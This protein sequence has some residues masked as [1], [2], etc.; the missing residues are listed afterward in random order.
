MFFLAGSCFSPL[1]ESLSY[2]A[3]RISPLC[4]RPLFTVL[5]V[6]FCFLS[7]HNPC[8]F[9]NLKRLWPGICHP[10]LNTADSCQARPTHFQVIPPHRGRPQQEGIPV[11]AGPLVGSRCPQLFTVSPAPPGCTSHDWG[12]VNNSWNEWMR[13]AG[14]HYSPLEQEQE[15][16][17]ELKL[18]FS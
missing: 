1:E 7:L 4:V 10:S 12:S 18:L 16:W 9:K 5:S 3:R 2:L 13:R 6:Y 17:K 15:F 11:S 14:H 8:C